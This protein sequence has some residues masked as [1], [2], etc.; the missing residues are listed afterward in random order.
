M[1]KGQ[2]TGGRVAGTPNK[3]P[4]DLRQAIIQAAK[5]ADPS[6]GE[7][8]IE[9]YLSWAATKAPGPYLALIG[10]MI[11][12]LLEASVKN[13]QLCKEQRDAVAAAFLRAD[14]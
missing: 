2:K 7:K 5:D 13:H 3:L 8:C 1:A 4:R 6:P 11:P 9:G 10:K 14:T 12:L